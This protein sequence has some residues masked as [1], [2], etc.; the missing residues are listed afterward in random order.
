M[1]VGVAKTCVFSVGG[2]LLAGYLAPISQTRSRRRRDTAVP[3]RDKTH[4]TQPRSRTHKTMRPIP[5]ERMAIVPYHMPAGPASKAI[6]S[7]GRDT[8]VAP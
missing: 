8:L 3:A 2:N 7:V 6:V 1:S 4:D 5:D